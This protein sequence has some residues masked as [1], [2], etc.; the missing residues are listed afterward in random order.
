MHVLTYVLTQTNAHR[1]TV[2]EEAI[3]NELRL[4]ECV[5][6]LPLQDVHFDMLVKQ[7]TA[8]FG[9]E[10]LAADQ[11]TRSVTIHSAGIVRYFNDLRAQIKRTVDLAI[12]R[13]IEDF[14]YL[15]GETDWFSIKNMLDDPFD[16]QFYM[17]GF[18]AGSK[19]GFA[20]ALFVLLG[21]EQ[22]DAL[23][24]EVTQMFDCHY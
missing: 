13:P 14:M 11:N 19:T 24:L 23:T 16:C 17:D 5:T 22:T 3:L 10:N 9:Q 8:L 21:Y 6:E 18:G 4:A 2:E 15:R 20:H 7:L 12:E 1:E